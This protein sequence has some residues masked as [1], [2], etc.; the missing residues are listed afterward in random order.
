[1]TSTGATVRRPDGA[2]SELAGERTLTQIFL[3]S[4]APFETAA[5]MRK[6]FRIGHHY[7]TLIPPG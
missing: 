6:H 4:L 2:A 3:A 7:W 1:M 5:R